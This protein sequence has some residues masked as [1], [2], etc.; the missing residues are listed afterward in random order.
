MKGQ[1]T[2]TDEWKSIERNL[3]SQEEEKEE[4][5]AQEQGEQLEQEVEEEE[6]EGV[7]QP[8]KTEKK[9][10]QES[11]DKLLKA[12]EGSED[13]DIFPDNFEFMYGK[14]NLDKPEEKKD[15][16]DVVEVTT[17]LQPEEMFEQITEVI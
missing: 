4:K 8:T 16:E 14:Q 1:T 15:E 10:V 2:T 9:Q 6:V 17:G 12:F 3:P 11:L 7:H 13:D 5:E